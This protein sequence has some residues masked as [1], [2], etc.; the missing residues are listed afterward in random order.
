MYV[1]YNK[2]K[3]SRLENPECLCQVL[4]YRDCGLRL[5]GETPVWEDDGASIHRTKKS[6]DKI[7]ELFEERIEC[8]DMAAKMDDVWP[9]ENVWGIVAEKLSQR[10]SIKTLVGLKRA[11]NEIWRGINE[12]TCKRLVYSTPLRL[13][14]V[15]EKGGNRLSRF[16]T[17]LLDVE[18]YS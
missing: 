15:I 3:H 8:E 1:W 16:K 2:P 4:L 12:E 14:K 7:S 17:N 5:V 6:R 9:I 11:I 18:M 10:K 13:K